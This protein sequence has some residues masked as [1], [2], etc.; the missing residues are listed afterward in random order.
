MFSLVQA[1]LIPISAW[2]WIRAT[3]IHKSL[4]CNNFPSTAPSLPGMC[5]KI[6]KTFALTSGQTFSLH[7]P[8]ITFTLCSELGQIFSSIASKPINI[9]W[10]RTG[11][12]LHQKKSCIVS[13]YRQI[14][15][16]NKIFFKFYYPWIFYYYPR[17]AVCYDNSLLSLTIM[18]YNY[19]FKCKIK[20]NKF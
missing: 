13:Y 17:K 10:I 6:W 15:T 12:H 14:S 5:V 4:G 8:S 18:S 20:I 9:R 11:S 2:I 16:N 19:H 7:S 3:Y 1:L